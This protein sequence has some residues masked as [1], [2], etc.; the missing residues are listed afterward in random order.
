M[1]KLLYI[2]ILTIAS[3]Y[4]YAAQLVLPVFPGGLVHR[5]AMA[6][7]PGISQ[8][9]DEPVV[10]EFKSGAAGLLGAKFLSEKKGPE[11][12][13]MI[14]SPHVWKES[15]ISQTADMIPIAFLGTSPGI[16]IAS[17]NTNYSDYG[18]FLEYS[19]KNKASYAIVGSS[20]NVQLFRDVHKKFEASLV[21]IPYRSGA[22]V[23]ADVLGGHVAVGMT[24]TDAV[25]QYVEQSKLVTLAIFASKRS[26][27]LPAVPTL[28]ELGLS[29][30]DASKYYNNIFLW[31]N[32]SADPIKVEL[33]KKR[34]YTYMQSEEM[35]AV[36]IKMDIQFGGRDFKDAD[37]LLKY[38]NED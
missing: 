12:T 23:I 15:S 6:L 29:T 9:L 7:T 8:A 5:Y 24:T 38:F 11:I 21:E 18:Q 19:K 20:S 16:V 4:T 34:F 10:H 27:L 35:K 22:Q 36:M 32:K 13:L 3:F 30:K 1:K 26:A 33:F 31:V 14:G 37:K 25:V 17:P 2:L 28:D